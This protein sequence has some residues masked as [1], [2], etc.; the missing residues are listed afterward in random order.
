MT[1]CRIEREG[2]TDLPAAKK[3]RRKLREDFTWLR[4]RIGFAR[5]QTPISAV[6]QLQQDCEPARRPR[7]EGIY[8]GNPRACRKTVSMFVAMRGVAGSLN[9]FRRAR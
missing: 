1:T 8:R 7:C 5:C 4:K 9:A 2:V 6:T 3:T